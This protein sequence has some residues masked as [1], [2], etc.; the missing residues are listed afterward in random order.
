MANKSIILK[1]DVYPY[2]RKATAATITPGM[3]CEHNGGLVR[4]HSTAGGTAAAIFATEDELQGNAITDDYAASSRVQLKHFRPGDEVLALLANGQAAVDG[5]VLVSDG[6]GFLKADP[7]E[8]SGPI[9]GAELTAHGGI[10]AI[11]LESL[12]MSGSDAVDPASQ[13]LKVRII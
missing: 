10:V 11:A 9:S 4:K 13:L 1:S 7:G 12:D 6:L 3:L 8:A 2:E 5:T